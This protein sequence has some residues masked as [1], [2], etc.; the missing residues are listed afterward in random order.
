[1]VRES[2]ALR[3][4]MGFLESHVLFISAVRGTVSFRQHFVQSFRLFPPSFP[5]LIGGFGKY[6]VGKYLHWLGQCAVPCGWL[7]LAELPW[8][9]VPCSGPVAQGSLLTPESPPTFAGT[10]SK[11][12]YWW[13]ILRTFFKVKVCWGL[14]EKKR[15]HCMHDETKPHN[16][17]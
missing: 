16:S 12:I 5:S 9:P 6:R 3:W 4:H 7:P 11:H 15:Q 14:T 17:K 13:W 10:I 8:M 2:C 1:M